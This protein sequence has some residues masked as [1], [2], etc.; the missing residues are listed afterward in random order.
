MT[1]KAIL[2]GGAGGVMALML[3]GAWAPAAQGQ[4]VAAEAVQSDGERPYTSQRDTPRVFR[5]RPRPERTQAEPPVQDALRRAMEARREQREARLEQQR[6]DGSGTAR[7]QE[8]IDRRLRARGIDRDNPRPRDVEGWRGDRRG[9]WRGRDR[10][11]DGSWRD[12]DD[13]RGDWRDERRDERVGDQ[14]R[15]DRDWRDGRHWNDRGWDSQWGHDRRWDRLG[16]RNDRRYDWHGWRSRNRDLFRPGRYDAPQR[17]WTYSRPRIGVFLGAPFFSS[18][19]HIGDPWRY[20]LPEAYGPYRWVRYYD[21]VL[22]VDLR[23][24]EVVDVVYDFFWR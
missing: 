4:Q 14:L 2:K 19:F 20:R 12:R 5:E 11:R 22:L 21:D 6:Q 15:R 7:Q 24:G 23:T 16:W 8:E 10:D 1:F 3:A 17:G 9:D 18:R 13:R